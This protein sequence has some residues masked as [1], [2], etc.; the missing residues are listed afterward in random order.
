VLK[1]TAGLDGTF[2]FRFTPT[3]SGLYTVVVTAPDHKGTSTTQ[4]RAVDPTSGSGDQ[5][6]PQAIPRLIRYVPQIL[7]ELVRKVDNLPPS[8][9][10]NNLKQK[11]QDVARKANDLD[12]P[13]NEVAGD[14]GTLLAAKWTIEDHPDKVYQ[15]MEQ[16]RQNVVRYLGEVESWEL[17]SQ[18]ELKAIK[19]RALLCDDL[20]VVQEGINIV[21]LMLN[22]FSPKTSD[23]ITSFAGDFIANPVGSGVASATNN[24]YAGFGASEAVK[25]R[26]VAVS[27]LK[28]E[29]ALLQ[30]ASG[31]V[32]LMNDEIG[33][34][35]SILVSQSCVTF[36]GPVT[37][38]MH[39][40]FFHEGRMWWEYAFDVRAQLT[41]HYPKS[42]SGG[43]VPLKG[44]L[45]GFANNY[46]VWEDSMSVMFPGLMSST[47]QKHLQIPPITA[48]DAAVNLPGAPPGIEGPKASDLA[49]HIR[50]VEG[51]LAGKLAVPSSFFFQ[52]TGTATESQ[53]TVKLGSGE[54]DTND[55]ETIVV[56][57]LPVWSLLPTV[58]VYPLPFKPVHFV[59]E[60]ASPGD[61]VIPLVTDGDVIKGSQSFKNQ[62]TSSNGEAEGEYTA[63][64]TVCNPGC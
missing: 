32:G 30:N 51:S 35:V 27:L 24:S 48:S 8:P 26:G 43:S 50:E 36:S 4:F 57:G 53:L 60:Q 23:I 34:G 39:A 54:R 33:L 14:L 37:A 44:R 9:A 28:K 47:V 45:E 1:S 58:W 3:V 13:A 7:D 20:E 10:K 38:H 56:L 22:L 25:Q 41:L 62:H 5:D 12:L 42:A 59:F 6:L 19:Q 18:E 63:E 16:E 49:V 15:R 40:K 21:S 52:V 17:R 2:S 46:K 55:S 11:M 64:F 61:Y 29:S 31:F